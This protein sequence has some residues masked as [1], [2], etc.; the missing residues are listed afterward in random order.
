MWN[1]NTSPLNINYNNGTFQIQFGYGKYKNMGFQLNKSRSSS[2]A[3][4]NNSPIYNFTSANMC[5]YTTNPYRIMMIRF[6][7]VT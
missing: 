6:G 7:I 3:T 1:R 5:F 4:N 2:K